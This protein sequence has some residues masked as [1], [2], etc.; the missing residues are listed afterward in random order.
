[1]L[2]FNCS[3]YYNQDENCYKLVGGFTG[4][5][6][7]FQCL[8]IC[9]FE[10]IRSRFLQLLPNESSKRTFLHGLFECLALL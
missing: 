1:M 10:D 6:W 2:F 4:K 5:G 8:Y 9:S 7:G 3:K